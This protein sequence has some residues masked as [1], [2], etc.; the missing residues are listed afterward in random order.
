MGS[1]ASH[2][3]ENEK[4]LT[5]FLKDSFL[6]NI[7]PVL[8]SSKPPTDGSFLYENALLKKP[9][10]KGADLAPFGFKRSGPTLVECLPLV[11]LHRSRARCQRL[12]RPV[13]GGN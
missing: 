2:S 5:I 8:T 4:T 6:K 1:G 11:L 13:F 7:Y 9:N 10:K 12:A 3:V